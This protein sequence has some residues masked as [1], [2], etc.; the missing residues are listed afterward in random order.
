[1]IAHL[2]DYKYYEDLYDKI[3]VEVGRR[4]GGALVKARD[5]FYEKTNIAEDEFNKMEFWWNRIYWWLVEIPFLLPRWEDKAST[6]REWMARDRAK[7]QQVEEARLQ[8]EPECEHCHRPG[9]RLVDKYLMQRPGS[10]TEQV[11]FM[12][13]CSGCKKKTAAW[14]DGSI[15]ER[16]KTYCPK[17]N[18]VMDEE[19]KENKRSITTTYSCPDCHHSY[20]SRLDLGTKKADEDSDFE[21]DRKIFCLS[22][23]RAR[24]MQE[25]RMKWE[26]VQNQMDE[27]KKREAEKDLYD[28]VASVEQ[29]KIPQLIERLRLPIEKAGYIELTFDKP[30]LGGYVTIRFNCMDSN[31]NREDAK[32]R[33]ALKKA[34]DTAL[35]DTNWRLMT[36]GIEY[37]LGYL[38]GKLRAYEH[39][40]DLV[41]LLRNLRHD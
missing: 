15:W 24:T 36:T 2:K 9:L 40:A 35:M 26:A 34:I 10:K 22:E 31:S 28:K 38:S 4:E 37:R 16:T 32:S 41:E 11:L 27:D 12:L 23:E 21:R 30:E 6:I 33:K 7:D 39:E 14:Q 19:V 13:A 8:A 17:C 1:M 20:K 29:L 3:T 5:Q 25:Y 18:C